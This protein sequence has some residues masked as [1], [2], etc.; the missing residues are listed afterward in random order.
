MAS[1]NEKDASAAPVRKEDAP[2]NEKRIDESESSSA[3]D[4]SPEQT[5]KVA[6]H[7]SHHV[8]YNSNNQ[9]FMPP[10]NGSD[11]LAEAEKVGTNDK[12]ELTE[13]DCYDELGFGFSSYKKWCVSSHIPKTFVFL[14][15]AIYNCSLF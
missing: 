3:H 6:P 15:E 10:T 5:D 8:R 4:A 14:D 7:E 12:I 9:V 11:D 2:M 13:D 1:L